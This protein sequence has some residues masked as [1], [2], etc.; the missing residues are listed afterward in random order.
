MS[1]RA[2]WRFASVAGPSPSGPATAPASAGKPVAA[3]HDDPAAAL[4]VIAPK[5]Y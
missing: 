2:I 5:V 3:T 4:S 1:S